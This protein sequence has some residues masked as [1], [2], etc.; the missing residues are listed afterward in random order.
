[1]QQA[2]AGAS[3][4][5][6]RQAGDPDAKV[7]AAWTTA[8]AVAEFSGTKRTHNWQFVDDSTAHGLNGGPASAWR[9]LLVSR[10]TP[11]AA[12][13]E[14]E[15]DAGADGHAGGVDGCRECR[16]GFLLQFL[17]GCVHDA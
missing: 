5:F 17:A 6:A 4:S 16:L 2:I 3:G 15:A 14:E 13:T 10:E 1:M 12:E 9:L 7:V 8:K 11:D